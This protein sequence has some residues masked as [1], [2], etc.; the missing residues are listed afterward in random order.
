MRLV[1]SFRTDRSTGGDGDES[2]ST[3][4]K[5]AVRFNTYSAAKSG[6]VSHADPAAQPHIAKGCF[7]SDCGEKCVV[8]G[9]SPHM[10][11]YCAAFETPH[12]RPG[13]IVRVSWLFVA[14]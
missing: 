5:A 7:M 3:T 6:C 2:P 10:D 9:A 11:R 8:C 12:D 14:Q 13:F 4:T 1:V